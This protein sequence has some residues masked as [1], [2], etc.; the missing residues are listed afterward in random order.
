MRSTSGWSMLD[1]GYA[2]RSA[3]VTALGYLEAGR[4]TI[5]ATTT[6]R[7]LDADAPFF[8]L[9]TPRREW[10]GRA[11]VGAT[12]RQAAIAGFAPVVRL[13][14]ERNRSTVG[15]FAYRR[16]AGEVGISRAF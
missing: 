7:R 12:L 3:G 9:A 6:V 4:A 16:V 11:V 10:L 2:N 8:L 13:I 1:R 5:F 15:L 14:V